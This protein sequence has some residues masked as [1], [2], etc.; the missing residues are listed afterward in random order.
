MKEVQKGVE[1]Q[2]VEAILKIPGDRK[3]SEYLKEN[4]FKTVALFAP[5]QVNIQIL[6]AEISI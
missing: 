5:R 4:L 1:A 6:S 2:N 3:N